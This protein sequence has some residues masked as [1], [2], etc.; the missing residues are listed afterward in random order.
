LA[1]NLGLALHLR[2]FL[3]GGGRPRLSLRA[4]PDAPPLLRSLRVSLVREPAEPAEALNGAEAPDSSEEL[5]LGLQ[6]FFAKPRLLSE[7]DVAR[8]RLC[9][10]LCLRARSFAC[11]RHGGC[12]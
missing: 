8:P 10:V 6:A 1:F 12:C 4:A 7:G 11:C 2:P 9:S 3:G 5:E